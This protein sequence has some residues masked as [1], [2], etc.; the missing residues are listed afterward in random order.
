M[1]GYS[2]LKSIQYKYV[3]Y[4]ISLMNQIIYI[5]YRTQEYTILILICVLWYTTNESDNTIYLSTSTNWVPGD[6]LSFI[7]I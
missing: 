2:D 7:V 1:Y 4:G 6:M 3:Y 5:Y